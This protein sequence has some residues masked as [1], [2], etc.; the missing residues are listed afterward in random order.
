MHWQTWFASSMGQSMC[1]VKKG[2]DGARFGLMLQLTV[3]T[4]SINPC[5]LLHLVW[6]MQTRK[7]NGSH[8]RDDLHK[9]KWKREKTVGDW[10]KATAKKGII[11]QDIDP[12]QL[13]YWSQWPPPPLWTLRSTSTSQKRWRSIKELTNN[14]SAF[15]WLSDYSSMLMHVHSRC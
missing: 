12:D 13:D 15:F 14:S 3:T 4:A 9:I 6:N 7:S 1:S 5:T 11:D 2:E 8:Q 10:Y